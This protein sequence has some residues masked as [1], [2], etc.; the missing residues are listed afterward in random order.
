M[1]TK[2]YALVLLAVFVISMVFPTMALAEKGSN[3]FTTGLSIPDT[4]V[5]AGE[6]FSTIVSV[7]NLD[8]TYGCDVTITTSS[9]EWKASFYLAAGQSQ[10]ET[11]MRSI[12]HTTD[13]YYVVT[14]SHGPD[15]SKTK[16]T[17]TKTVYVE[18]ESSSE[19]DMESEETEPEPIDVI[20]GDEPDTEP[21][22]VGGV[23]KSGSIAWIELDNIVY[24]GIDTSLSPRDDGQYL[25]SSF[26]DPV[27]VSG[28]IYYN[29]PDSIMADYSDREESEYI[30]VRLWIHPMG[31]AIG[32]ME[33]IHEIY[34]ISADAGEIDFAYTL[35][36]NDIPA[37]TDGAADYIY[38]NASMVDPLNPGSMEDYFWVGIVNG[39]SD[40]S[41]YSLRMNETLVNGI[42]VDPEE[43]IELPYGEPFTISQNIG[44]QIPEEELGMADYDRAVINSDCLIND[45]RI[46]TVFMPRLEILPDVV[47]G[48]FEMNI[49][50]DRASFGLAGLDYGVYEVSISSAFSRSMYLAPAIDSTTAITLTIEI[51][52]PGTGWG[53]PADEPGVGG[54]FGGLM[55]LGIFE[56]LRDW[57][58][59][60]G[61]V[62]DGISLTPDSTEILLAGPEA[63]RLSGGIAFSGPE[64]A[65]V[66][67]SGDGNFGEPLILDRFTA[68][69]TARYTKWVSVEESTTYTVTAELI[70]EDGSILATDTRTVAV[71]ID[72]ESPEI[73]YTQ[74]YSLA[75]ESNTIES[76]GSTTLY[77]SL[78]NEFSGQT[79]HVRLYDVNAG[80]VVF[81]DEDFAPD[82]IRDGMVEKAPETTTN[83]EFIAEV[84]ADDGS[85]IWS[86][87]RSERIE[88]LPVTMAE[89]GEETVFNLSL[90]ASDT[91]VTPGEEVTIYGTIDYG[92]Y[93]PMDAM[94]EISV[95]VT[96]Q[97]GHVLFFDTSM[98][99]GESVAFEDTYIMDS[100]TT[101]FITA[102]GEQI[103][104]GGRMRD[105][106]L[107]SIEVTDLAEDADEADSRPSYDMDFIV[108]VS[109]TLIESGGSVEITA[110]LINNGTEEVY[111]VV[112]EDIGLFGGGDWLAPG[113]AL[114]GTQ[115][116]VLDAT[117]MIEL[118]ARAH[119]MV[120]MAIFYELQTIT[121]VVDDALGTDIAEEGYGL[122]LDVL[123]A[124]T[125]ITRGETTQLIIDVENTGENAVSL[126]VSGDETYIDGEPFAPGEHRHLELYWSPTETSTAYIIAGG[127]D[128][129]GIW[130]CRSA[131]SATVIVE[132]PPAIDAAVDLVVTSD[133]DG[134]VRGVESANI[135][136]DITNT[137]TLPIAQ[138]VIGDSLDGLLLVGGELPPGE[139][140]H[141]TLPPW[142]PG[143]TMT[144]VFALYA[145]NEDGEL[146]AMDDEA[147][148]IRVVE[149]EAEGGEAEP[150]EPADAE[151]EAGPLDA[152]DGA[153][154]AEA[155]DVPLDSDSVYS[156]GIELSITPVSTEGT[157]EGRIVL[158]NGDSDQ[159]GETNEQVYRFRRWITAVIAAIALAL[160][161]LVMVLILLSKK[162]KKQKK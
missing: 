160:I 38:F 126:L 147:L 19:D 18:T 17:S 75:A 135:A 48:E 97:D 142:S 96:D 149:P 150:P 21:G 6:T 95:E 66:R 132:D 39:P 146:V 117:T 76:G 133:T 108:E 54:V 37:L 8:P 63:L 42:A 102:Q 64:N 140:D 144:V 4:T 69:G 159:P 138:Y 154:A 90:S 70:A 109:D 158:M 87:M 12:Q 1:K 46:S 84:L 116:L 61:L 152:A 15:I 93:D 71:T 124:D 23:P 49:V 36:F 47:E 111:G 129:S 32:C 11:I 137:G 92:R 122:D 56:R 13:I 59:L 136:L 53:D 65:R 119:T 62:E 120:D 77:Y 30:Q 139:T 145:L 41:D 143:R 128:E 72:G 55:E 31:D 99:P 131:E 148:V 118:S 44:Y 121:I 157:R 78:S 94:G 52:D 5:E 57:L 107:L 28:E 82:E 24:D 101:F 110:T 83:Y 88:V 14:A 68:E 80:E 50:G 98:L 141:L 9:G 10:S 100:S 114:T 105:I 74:R 33:E 86:Q 127:I 29:L 73:D 85:V 103:A 40:T 51:V 60:G 25:V 104:G 2:R 35:T 161:V 16:N 3:D 20:L 153:E 81:E 27:D 7:K 123:A 45:E 67:I 22:P 89:D 43:I 34:P 134:I 106:D 79:L 91:S 112:L 130:V 58:G 115:T 26:D 151:A 156:G 113:E 125:M 155:G 162:R